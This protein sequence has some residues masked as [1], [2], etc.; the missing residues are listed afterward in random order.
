M[1]L[2]PSVAGLTFR[3]ATLDD[4]AG[5]AAHT[6]KVHRAEQ[7]DFVPGEEFFRWLMGQPNLDPGAD[8][9]LGVDTDG[10]IVADGGAWAT[11]TDEG[12]RVILWFETSPDW[13]ATKPDLLDWAET[14]AAEQLKGVTTEWTV[15]VPVE[16]HRKP[17]RAIIEEAGFEVGR[18]FV[19]MYRP[20]DDLPDPPELPSGIEVTPWQPAHTQAARL[21]SNAAFASHWGTLP[22]TDE[23]WRA[24]ITE[25]ETFQADLSYVAIAEGDVV[26]FC[27]GEVDREHNENEGVEELWLP[28]IGTIPSMQRRG[29]ATAL[30]V[31]SLLA[32]KDAGLERAGLDVDESSTTNAT[33]VYERI[34]FEAAKRSLQYIKSA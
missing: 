6:A 25:S 11:L 17:H 8:M 1:A 3:P 20:L 9:L 2:P 7:L 16:E 26:A 31:A 18:S 30:I 13:A 19:E 10:A 27:L 5:L 32:G 15:R 23:Q 21:A 4:A 29:I 22:L 33:L 28:R 24:L 12:A 34:G 14:R